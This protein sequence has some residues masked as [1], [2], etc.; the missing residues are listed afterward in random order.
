MALLLGCRL[1]G[2][3]LLLRKWRLAW[4]LLQGRLLGE[5]N[6]LLR[7][8]L[9]EW[10]RRLDLSRGLRCLLLLKRRLYWPSRWGLWFC[11]LLRTLGCLRLLRRRLCHLPCGL[12]LGLELLRGWLL[13]WH[14]RRLHLLFFGKQLRE[15]EHWL[16]FR[17]SC[18]RLLGRLHVF[19]CK[20]LWK[21][22]QGLF[23]RH[24]VDWGL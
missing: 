6:L 3:E 9:D 12:L 18:E 16:L 21:R 2:R 4:V 15:C 8:R 22:K 11:H 23:R 24:C 14:L 20:K 5:G 17:L 13:A 19:L 1:H 7:W 10:L